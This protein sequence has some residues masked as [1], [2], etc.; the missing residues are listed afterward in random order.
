M[1]GGLAA[2]EH[3]ADLLAGTRDAVDERADA[4]LV[5]LA[6]R[7]VIE[8]VGR[9][10]SVADDIVGAHRHQILSD[11]VIAIEPARDLSLGA[12]SVG[13]CHDQR[14]LHVGGQLGDRAKLAQ[15]SESV[16]VGHRPLAPNA[17]DRAL[18][19]RHVDARIGVRASVGHPAVTSVSRSSRSLWLTT[20]KGTGTG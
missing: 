6:N 19:R 14:P 1:L 5:D 16:G 4:L 20:S 7:D 17:L 2:N 18:C 3:A 9:L 11:G 15:P 10:R 13:R 12:H 8:E